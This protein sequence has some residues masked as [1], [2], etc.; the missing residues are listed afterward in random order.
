MC[1]GGRLEEKSGVGTE[2][3]YI[4]EDEKLDSLDRLHE[5]MAQAAN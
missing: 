3:S 2:R 4:R 5:P 1:M